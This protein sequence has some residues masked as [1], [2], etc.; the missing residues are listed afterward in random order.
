MKLSAATTLFYDTLEA[1]PVDTW[2]A[3]IP[4]STSGDLKLQ[5]CLDASAHLEELEPSVLIMPIS[6]T[7]SME[8]SGRRDNIKQLNKKPRV[9]VVI[10]WPF[11]SKDSTGLD[12]STWAE[13]VKIINLREEID[14][15]LAKEIPNIDDIETDPPQELLMDKRVFL[16]ITDFYLDT[17]ICP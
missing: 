9:S 12:L 8:G 1:A 6:S 7:Y 3:Y 10:T 16:S 13:I 4:K 5:Y 2:S 15:Y 17:V 11:V 14:E